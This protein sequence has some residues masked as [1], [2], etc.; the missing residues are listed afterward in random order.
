MGDVHP[1]IPPIL[2]ENPALD[3]AKRRYATD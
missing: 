2:L 1:P 3:L